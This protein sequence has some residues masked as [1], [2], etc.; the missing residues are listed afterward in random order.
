I[1]PSAP[2]STAEAREQLDSSGAAFR[3][4]LVGVSEDAF[5]TVRPVG[6]EEYSVLS[7]LENVAHHDEE[8]CIQIGAIVA[9]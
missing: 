4:A 7:L 8:H 3:S 9:S 2:S 1:P 5:Y 6:H